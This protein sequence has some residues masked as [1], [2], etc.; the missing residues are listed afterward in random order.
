MGI[1]GTVLNNFS[2][3]ILTI[4]IFDAG[5]FVLFILLGNNYTSYCMFYKNIL[6]KF[7]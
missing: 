6:R 1:S 7:D 2:T 3:E 5:Y 4:E